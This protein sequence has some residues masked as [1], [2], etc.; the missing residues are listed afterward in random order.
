[1][2]SIALE[3]I[4]SFLIFSSIF[5]FTIWLTHFWILIRL[6][7]S[8]WV[9]IITVS[10]YEPTV[11]VH[12]L[13]SDSFLIS[14]FRSSILSSTS[15]L[16]FVVVVVSLVWLCSTR[17]DIFPLEFIFIFSSTPLFQIILTVLFF[18]I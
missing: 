7:V 3:I 14:P 2:F 9:S 8:F 18:D 5:I 12:S 4:I 13:R 1:M 15:E 17:K 11:V 6:A 10:S 16:Y